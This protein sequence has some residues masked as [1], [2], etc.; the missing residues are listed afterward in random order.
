MKSLHKIALGGGCH[1]CTEAVF[2]SLIGV[3]NVE[4]GFVASNGVNETFSE[5]VIVHY[6]ETEISLKDL[7]SIHLNTH[8]STSDHSMRSK[9]RSAVYAF[10]EKEIEKVEQLLIELQ[11]DFEKMLVT[12]VYPFRAFKPS[13]QMFHGYYYSNTEK[14]FCKRY[15]APKLNVLFEKFSKHLNE[16][17]ES[18]VTV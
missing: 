4:Q 3:H 6:D 13:A 12:R 8:E 11:D 16:N 9:Y 15:I 5:A 10:Q 18:K 17:L 7:I 2:Q 14:P 1:W